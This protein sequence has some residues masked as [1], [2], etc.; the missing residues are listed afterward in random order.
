LQVIE[1]V[2]FLQEKVQK[3]ESSYP[4]WSDENA[5]LMPWVIFEAIVND[6]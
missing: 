1:Y 2:Q 6:K 5:K 3:Y 4:G